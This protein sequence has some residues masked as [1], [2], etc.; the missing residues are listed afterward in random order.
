MEIE[1]TYLG[2]VADGKFIPKETIAEYFTT[3][4]GS[5]VK[6]IGEALRHADPFNTYKLLD[7]FKE[8]V[9]QYLNVFNITENEIYKSKYPEPIEEK[10]VASAVKVGNII[11]IG[12]RHGDAIFIARKVYGIQHVGVDREGFLTNYGRYLD[13]DEALKFLKEKD[14]RRRGNV[15][16]LFSE[17]LR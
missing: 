4:G 3:Y 1:V 9:I 12:K 5:F 13:R 10:L 15:K 14:E 8:Y 6:S 17:D 7:T 11:A 2:I 16:F